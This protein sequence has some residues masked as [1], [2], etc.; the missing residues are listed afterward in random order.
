MTSFRQIEANRRNVNAGKS[1]GPNTEEGKHRSRQ[2]A[3]RH[4]LC[5]ETVVE[6]V[7]DIDDYRGFEA[8]VIADYDARTAVERE[9]VLRLASLLWRL[10]R[11]TAIETD[12]LRIQAEILR[13]RGQGRSPDGLNNRASPIIEVIAPLNDACDKSSRTDRFAAPPAVNSARQ[14]T[15]CFQR[16]GNLDHGVFE[17]LGRY[18]S[19]IGRQ[20]LKTL[21]LLRSVRAEAQHTRGCAARQHGL[22][23]C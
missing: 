7:E 4:G 8:A 3:I 10:R 13:D 21:Y 16:L 19:A 17:R 23:R 2:N 14:L 6:I 20:V 22:L 12:L 15:L 5:A 11:A 1:T 9:L 18:E